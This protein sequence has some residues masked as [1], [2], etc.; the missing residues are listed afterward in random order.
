M[1]GNWRAARE[2][3][4]PLETA[5]DALLRAAGAFER[6]TGIRGPRSDEGVWRRC[7]RWEVWHDQEIISLGSGELWSELDAIALA[8]GLTPEEKTVLSMAHVEEY[9]L[10][11]MAAI[12]GVTVYRVRLL[13]ARAVRK[14]RRLAPDERVSAHSLF[15]EEIRQKCASIYRRPVHN[16]RIKR[17]VG[18]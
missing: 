15:W 9:S 14:C 2:K 10:R 8:A 18:D 11:E 17:T 1:V 7:C 3:T 13:L 5:A 16:W 12:L 6:G 4:D